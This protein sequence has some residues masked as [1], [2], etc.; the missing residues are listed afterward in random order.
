MPT[1][2]KPEPLRARRLAETIKRLLTAWLEQ[3]PEDRKPGFVTVTDVRVSRDLGHAKVYY[4]VL[5]EA[6]DHEAA[7]ARLEE[8]TPQARA[9][10]AQHVRLRHAPTVEFLPDDVVA[11][12]ARIDKLLADLAAADTTQGAGGDPA[13][14]P[15][16]PDE[17]SD[18]RR[19]SR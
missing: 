17:P 6:A 4:T 15:D 16:S 12:G 7:A 11:T 19:G 10:V 5:G 2:R 8:M 18:D 3:Q 13:E 1:D 14:P 9:W